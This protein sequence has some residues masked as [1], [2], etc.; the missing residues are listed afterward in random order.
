MEKPD[1]VLPDKAIG[2]GMQQTSFLVTSEK[3]RLYNISIGY[4][5]D[6]LK[7]SDLSFTYELSDEFKVNPTFATC[8]N[9]L[10]VIFECLQ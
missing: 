7:K 10:E 4:S 6:P 5:E 2:Y 8:F 3:A 1:K 9:K